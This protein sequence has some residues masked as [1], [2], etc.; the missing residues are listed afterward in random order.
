MAVPDCTDVTGLGPGFFCKEGTAGSPC[1][2]S[3]V[4]MQA[5]L[6]AFTCPFCQ[7]TVTLPDVN[8]GEVITCTNPA[9]Q[10]KFEADLPKVLP[11]AVSHAEP[12]LIVPPGVRETAA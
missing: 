7:H 11:D 12:E 1:F 9:C 5:T 2:E 10:K 4:F 8:E 6:Y 3:E